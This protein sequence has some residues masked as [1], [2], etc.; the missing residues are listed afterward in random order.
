MSISAEDYAEGRALNVPGRGGA[1]HIHPNV[2]WGA[3][4]VGAVVAV[5]LGTMLNTLGLATAASLIETLTRET[6]TAQSMAVGSGIWLAVS[7]AIALFLGALAAARLAHSWNTTDSALHGLAVWGVS[8][9]LA[10]ALL[11]SALSG[12]IAAGVRGVGGAA[13][14]VGAAAP[15]LTPE[16]ALEGLQGRLFGQ[17]NPT[18]TPREE[19]IGEASQIFL[20]RIRDGQWTPQ[21]RQRLEALVAAIS[22]VP[23]QEAATRINETEAVVQASLQRAEETARRAADAAARSTAIGAFWAFASLLL[24]LGAAVLGARSGTLPA[25]AALGQH[26]DALRA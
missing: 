6:P 2:S 21:D 4:M 26:R 15:A 8:T 18:A 19:A 24:G 23:Q 9:L 11:G 10:A 22:G 1:A 13:N 12:G 3:I 5:S 16:T 20:R 17:S 25:R 14:A 7:T